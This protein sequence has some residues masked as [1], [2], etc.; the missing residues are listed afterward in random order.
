MK[1]IIIEKGKRQSVILDNEGRFVR[2][3]NKKSW[4]EGNE[5]SF[6]SNSAMAAKAVSI[7]LTLVLVLTMSLF[8]VYAANSYTV[9]MDVNPSISLELN[10]FN[11]VK[12]I[13]ALND[14][15][16]KISNLESLIGLKLG[17]AV[18]QAILILIEEG[19]LE[20]DGTV[21]LSVEGS[22]NKVRTVTR[23]VSESVANANV[24]SEQKNAGG[25]GK[26]GEDGMNIYIGRITQEIA[27]AAEEFN[28]PYGRALLVAKAIEEGSDINYETAGVLSVRE[29]QRI[30]NISKTMEKIAET[31]SADKNGNSN[32]PGQSNQTQALSNKVYK[33]A[34]KI[35]DYLSELALIIEAGEADEKILA[36]YAEL[37]DRL[38]AMYLQL[39][40]SGIGTY[41]EVMSTVMTMTKNKG[42]DA[43]LKAKVKNEAEISLNG[44]QLGKPDD[45]K[46]QDGANEDDKGKGNEN[47]GDNGN[48]TTDNGNSNSGDSGS[49]NGSGSSGSDNKGNSGSSGKGGN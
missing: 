11:T 41:E 8:G 36:E 46:Q 32:N 31:E 39:E 1:G 47:S 45:N 34:A 13:T 33:E 5:V 19:Y 20:E 28:I 6:T 17:T 24:E 2:S 40:Q 43:Q 4:N 30:R 12:D 48:S 35:E 9:N 22:N 7:A 37:S 23:A 18:N 44:G 16:E 3:K 27:E 38:D 49:D 25:N 26:I 14:D 42:A 29:I 15:A 21:V 10:A